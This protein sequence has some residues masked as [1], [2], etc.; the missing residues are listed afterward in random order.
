LKT[1]HDPIDRKKIVQENGGGVFEV[2]IIGS[3]FGPG[4]TFFQ[5]SDTVFIISSW[6][7][8]P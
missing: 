6:S 5:E 4:R 2:A 8:A 1:E 7:P 3:T